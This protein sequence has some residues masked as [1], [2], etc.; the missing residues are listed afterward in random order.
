MAVDPRHDP[1]DQP[2][3]LIEL[4]DCTKVLSCSKVA[5]DFLLWSFCCDMGKTPSVGHDCEGA[6]PSPPPPLIASPLAMRAVGAHWEIPGSFQGNGAKCVTNRSQIDS[7]EILRFHL[8]EDC[9]GEVLEVDSVVKLFLRSKGALLCL[10]ALL[11]GAETFVAEEK[12]DHRSVVSEGDPVCELSPEAI[13]D[14]AT[15]EQSSKDEQPA[16]SVAVQ[17]ESP[18]TDRGDKAS[19]RRRTHGGALPR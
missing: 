14:L 5:R 18:E 6:I 9:D 19:F 13:A 15:P 7:L 3:S 12:Q 17:P 1:S 8:W 11:A 16:A 4:D 2:T 10:L